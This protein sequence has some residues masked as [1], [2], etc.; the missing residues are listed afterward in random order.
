[1]SAA[2][3]TL[4][5]EYHAL[6]VDPRFGYA[7]LPAA[8]VKQAPLVIVTHGSDRD[9]KGIVEYMREGLGAHHAS[10]LAPFFPAQLDGE[11]HGDGYKFLYSQGIDYIALMQAML[12]DAFETYGKPTAIYLLGFSGGAQFAQRYALF[13]GADLSGLV[14]A[15]PGG[16]TLLDETLEW[17]PGLQGAE[18][19]VGYKPDLVSFKRLPVEI[20]IGDQDMSA[21]LVDRPAG[22]PHGTAF[23]GFAGATRIERA[24]RLHVDLSVNEV[25]CGYHEL[26]GVAHELKPTT[27]KAAE[28][29]SHWIDDSKA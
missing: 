7:F 11:A 1:M 26:S 2:S 27:L 23:S 20:I 21:G 22:V 10:I 15:A 25:R 3:E 24:R 17:W 19:A 5:P 29:I 4:N 9:W 8:S 18:D 6:Q 16:V 28:L 14:L 13:C 12:N